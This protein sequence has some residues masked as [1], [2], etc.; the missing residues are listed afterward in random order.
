MK[1]PKHKYA[2]FLDALESFVDM[3]ANHP[4]DKPPMDKAR[5]RMLAALDELMGPM[6]PF[7]GKK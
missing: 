1:P 7:P 3:R 5:Q 6:S 4:N 2:E